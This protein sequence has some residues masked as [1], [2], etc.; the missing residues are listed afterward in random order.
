MNQG[1]NMPLVLDQIPVK[2][3]SFTEYNVA[4]INSIASLYKGFRQESKAP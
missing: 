3:I 1:E 2:E 4:S